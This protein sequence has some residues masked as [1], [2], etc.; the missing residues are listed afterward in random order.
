MDHVNR[1]LLRLKWESKSI[2][3][4]NFPS[5]MDTR[6][7]EE[8]VSQWGSDTPVL[9]MSRWRRGCRNFQEDTV[10]SWKCYWNFPCCRV[11]MQGITQDH[12]ILL[13]LVFLIPL[14]WLGAQIRLHAA[15]SEPPVGT[16]LP[17]ATGPQGWRGDWPVH[18]LPLPTDTHRPP[19]GRAQPATL[20]YVHLQLFPVTQ[21][22]TFLSI[23]ANKTFFH[24]QIVH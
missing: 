4:S 23:L 3:L 19:S 14:C 2:E 12:V 9:L 20:F 7:S 10:M 6:T 21:F 16:R 1:Y 15:Q 13:W 18:V 24:F 17:S 8:Q 22:N 11:Q 5:H